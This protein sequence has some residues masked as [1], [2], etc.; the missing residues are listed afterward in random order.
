MLLYKNGGIVKQP[1]QFEM[2]G[3]KSYFQAAYATTQSLIF[4]QDLSCHEQEYAFI[5]TENFRWNPEK[6]KKLWIQ[7]V[8]K[9]CNVYIQCSLKW[10]QDIM[11]IKTNGHKTSYTVK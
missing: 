7:I 1:N 5:S 6:K 3:C 11:D 2:L 9:N 8:K 10:T 4:W